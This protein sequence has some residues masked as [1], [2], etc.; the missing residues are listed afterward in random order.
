[1]RTRDRRVDRAS[2]FQIDTNLVNASGG[3]PNI[4]RLEQW[5]S[6]GV[7]N[8][9]MSDVAQSEAAIGSPARAR[10]AFSRIVT[11]STNLTPQEKAKR[12]E[13]EGILFPS[14][15]SS[16][17]EQNDVDI[18]FHAWKNRFTLITNDG[19]SHRQPGGILGRRA[20]LAAIG[21]KVTSDVDAVS[22]VEE[23]VCQRD[24][25]ERQWSQTTGEQLPGWVGED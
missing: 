4:N 14:G 23:Q 1:M 3:L 22:W 24:E 20:A 7:V 8:I 15:A 10:K 6:D 17:N 13:I 19:A 21:V 5:H 16:T 9:S 12:D 2:P 25:R 11:V 18:V